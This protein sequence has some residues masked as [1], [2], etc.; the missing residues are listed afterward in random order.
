V[1]SRKEGEGT[2]A[3]RITGGEFRSRALRA[4]KGSATRPTSDRV[5]E[6]LFSILGPRGAA[7]RVL[8]LYAGTGALGLEALSRGA[9]AVV[10]VERS[11]EAVAAIQANIEGLGV[12]ARARVLA[13][14]IERALRGLVTS[15]GDAFDLVFADPPYADV[16]S[17]A[18][19][20]LLE[21]H[22]VGILRPGA[23]LVLE[24]ASRDETPGIAGLSPRDSR[25]YGDTSVSF[26]SPQS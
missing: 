7:G 10:F 25:T 19:V 12:R 9:E 11:K 14:P 4:P 1:L 13:L 2:Q 21:A 18:A 15:E 16:A 17:G 20:K 8:D 6:A 24:H 23:L 5:R 22:V 3:M 26:Y